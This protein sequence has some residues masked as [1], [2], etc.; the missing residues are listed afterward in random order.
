[1]R[2]RRYRRLQLYVHGGYEWQRGVVRRA[3]AEHQKDHGGAPPRVLEIACGGGNLADLFDGPSYLGVDLIPERVQAAAAEHPRH[4]FIV[5]DVSG[6]EFD[7][8]LSGRDFVFC[9]GLLHHLDDLQCRRLVDLVGSRL[10]RPATFLAI[11]PWR[12]SALPNL[13]GHLLC[14]LDDGKFIRPRHGYVNVFGKNLVREERN[15]NWPR[16][17]VHMEAYTARYG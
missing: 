9:H 15:S 11:E 6:P 14:L 5:G 17:P 1:M 12:P 2:Y 10:A 16:W 7:Q 13:P 3:L 8:V 4:R